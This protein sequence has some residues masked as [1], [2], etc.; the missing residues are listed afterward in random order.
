MKYVKIPFIKRY[1]LKIRRRLEIINIDDEYLTR[2]QAAKILTNAILIIIPL[3]LAI[4]LITNE[5]TLLMV[6]L[7]VFEVFLADTL[8]GGMVDK[9][10]SRL[11]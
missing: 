7:L 9:N 1:L 6:F 10:I 5:N 8:I 4:I 3:T 11:Y 2:K